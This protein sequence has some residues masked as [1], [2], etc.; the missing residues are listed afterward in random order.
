MGPTAAFSACEVLAASIRMDG[1][2]VSLCGQPMHASD[3]SVVRLDERQFILGEGPLVA[4]FHERTPIEVPDT[5][6]AP[7]HGWRRLDLHRE[8][9][10]AVFAFPMVA[11]DA[12]LGAVTLY[13]HHP[14]TLTAAQRTLAELAA[15]AA[16]VETAAL[17]VEERAGHRPVSA[18]RRIGELRQAVGVVMEQLDIDAAAA[19]SLIRAHIDGADRPMADVIADLRHHR[20]VLCADRPD[21]SRTD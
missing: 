21:G 5:I 1:V 6:D 3:P 10:G 15:D 8:G 20:L 7:R 19:T 4:A 17:L 11:G 9:I 18:L 16:S 13:R 2:G 12:C 14:G